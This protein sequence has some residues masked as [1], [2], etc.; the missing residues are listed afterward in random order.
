MKIKLKGISIKKLKYIK[1]F[2]IKKCKN[3]NKKFV[4]KNRKIVH[5]SEDCK[6]IYRSKVQKYNSKSSIYKNYRLASTYEL[7]TAYILDKKI[8]NGDIKYWNYSRSKFI[9]YIDE[10]GEKKKYIFDFIYTDNNDN[11]FIIEV[12]GY[13][14]NNDLYKWKAAREQ[15]YNLIVWYLKDIEFQEKIYNISILEINNL[16]LECIDEHNIK[17]KER[18]EKQIIFEEYKKSKP[19]CLYC[20]NEF[21]PK[22]GTQL[23]CCKQHLIL[24][25]KDKRNKN[26]EI[27]CN[28]CNKQFIKNSN[29]QKYCCNEH[30]LLDKKR[31]NKHL[32]KTSYCL[33]C[34]KE[35]IKNSNVQKHCCN[36]HKNLHKDKL[37]KQKYNIKDT[38]VCL[39]CGKEF[40]RQSG[41]QKYC[42]EEHRDLYHKIKLKES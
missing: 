13:K 24:Y 1:H 27:T 11:Q 42:C 38:N 40:I 9:Y 21:I 25:Y 18:L 16:I 7:R 17:L 35:F 4:T 6:Y 22:N 14:V 20:N 30:F 19:K 3:C 12:K 23:F 15:G 34:G 37:R 10:N 36:E 29:T 5:C 26:C 33:Y 28:Y 2:Y 31:K 39:Y 32:P 41:R 8:E